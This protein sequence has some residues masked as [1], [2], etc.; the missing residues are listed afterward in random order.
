MEKAG[1]DLMKL[2]AVYARLQSEEDATS[3]ASAQQKYCEAQIAA[4]RAVARA[5]HGEQAHEP[6][7]GTTPLLPR[8]VARA[9]QRKKAAKKKKP[10]SQVNIYLSLLLV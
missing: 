3:A 9:K 8:G 1:V 10:K 2:Y 7:S 5:K 4:A 6:S